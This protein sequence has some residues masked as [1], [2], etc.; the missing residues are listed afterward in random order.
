MSLSTRILWGLLALC[1]CA[2]VF[3]AWMNPHLA[4][5]VASLVRSCF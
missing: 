5:E 1:A 3:L 2:A 4:L